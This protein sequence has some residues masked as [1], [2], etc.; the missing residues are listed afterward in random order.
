M[1]AKDSNHCAK[2]VNVM[3]LLMTLT[4]MTLM[5]MML[6]FW[7]VVITGI[8]LAIRWLARQGERPRSDGALDILRERYARGDINKDEFEGKQRDLR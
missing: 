3:L 7:S 2:K 1:E 6:V 5:M 4:L 8:V